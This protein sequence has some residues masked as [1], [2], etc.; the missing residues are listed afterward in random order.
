MRTRFWASGGSACAFFCGDG[1]LV[2]ASLGQCN[3]DA[4]T[5][6][7]KVEVSMR[8]ID[9]CLASCFPL[10]SA[11]SAVR[12]IGWALGLPLLLLTAHTLTAQVPLA[13]NPSPSA[14][15]D[16]YRLYYGAQ[17][18]TYTAGLDVGPV[19][20]YTVAG[21]TSGQI[22][23]FVVTAYD[24]TDGSESAVSNE[25]SVTLLRSEELAPGGPMTLEAEAMAL[26]GY[27]V[28]SNADASGGAPDQ[29]L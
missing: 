25:V 19:T 11:Y 4:T 26:A 7:G 6:L 12:P 18:R 9:L 29:S 2:S 20:T 21:L 15:A 14:T 23:Y 13:W 1:P 8:V 10:F 22:Y 16:G 5:V 27:L 24:S 17:S 28:E 3:K